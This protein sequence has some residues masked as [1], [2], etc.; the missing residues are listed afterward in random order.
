MDVL[1]PRSVAGSRHTSAPKPPPPPVDLPTTNPQSPYRGLPDDPP[2]STTTQTR[3]VA[4]VALDQLI[5]P[6][7]RLPPGPKPAI[8]Q[9]DHHRPPRTAPA[10]PNRSLP[11]PHP[12]RDQQFTAW[13]NR[14]ATHRDP[15]VP[16]RAHHGFTCQRPTYYGAMPDPLHSD[17]TSSRHTG[18]AP[19]DRRCRPN[20]PHGDGAW[21]ERVA[22]APPGL[23][24]D[25]LVG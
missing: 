3:H 23:R 14:H 16:A 25:V 19:N 7:P 13:P 24:V 22:A 5:G 17:T 20:W 9:I 1:A 21:C 11:R 18:S 8:A 15:T 6:R 12:D 4:A 10:S 2:D